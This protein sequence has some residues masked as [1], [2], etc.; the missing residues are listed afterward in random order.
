VRSESG[1]IPKGIQL[2]LMRC[3]ARRIRWAMV[4][5]GTRKARAISAVVKPP[6]ARKVGAT[7]EDRGAGGGHAWVLSDLKT[8][9]ETGKSFAN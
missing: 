5:S 6:T 7:L 2:A 3:L 4:A 1:R 9:L 8:L